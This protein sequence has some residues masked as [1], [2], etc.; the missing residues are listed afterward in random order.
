MFYHFWNIKSY[1]LHDY[2]LLVINLQFQLILNWA[3]IIPHT[4][5]ITTYGWLKL[6]PN[7]ILLFI[8][9]QY[10]TVF[11]YTE[12]PLKLCG[13]FKS[14][15]KFCIDNNISFVF[16]FFQIFVC[17]TILLTEDKEIH[18]SNRSL[19]ILSRVI[20]FYGVYFIAC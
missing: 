8:S 5:N 18:A 15:Q 7:S 6:K 12:S 17:P 4:S 1:E 3:K 20:R 2:C 14:Q 19:Y 13:N 10:R 11:F 9:K 16:K